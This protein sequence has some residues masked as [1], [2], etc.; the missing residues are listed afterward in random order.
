MLKLARRNAETAGA[1]N[2]SFVEAS[3]TSIPLPDAIADCI[4]SNCVINLVPTVDKHLAFNEMFRLLGPGGRVVISDILTRKELP[5]EVVNNLSFYVGCIA[6]ASRVHEYEKYLSVGGFK[7]ISSKCDCAFRISLT[8]FF[9]G[10]MVVDTH[11]DINVYKDLVQGQMD[12]GGTSNQLESSPCC[13]GTQGKNAS[14]ADLL[15]FD[16]NEWAGELHGISIAEPTLTGFH[17]GSFQI[18]A[19]KQ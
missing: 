13:G 2:A 15:E 17:I 10:V 6:G 11:S 12:L 9:L 3:I 19:V 5:Q 4:I 14:G 1:S 16:F 18:Y 7:G 8:S